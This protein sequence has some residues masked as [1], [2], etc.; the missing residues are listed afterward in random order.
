MPYLGSISSSGIDLNSVSVLSSSR[1][2][3]TSVPNTLYLRTSSCTPHGHSRLFRQGF[4]RSGCR[5]NTTTLAF[6]RGRSSQARRSSWSGLWRSA[7]AA[8]RSRRA[9]RTCRSRVWPPPPSQGRGLRRSRSNGLACNNL[10]CCNRPLW[11]LNIWRA[12]K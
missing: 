2:S 3:T 7:F 12:G 9:R 8:Q 1:S 5:I 10:T 6:Y 11:P 4:S